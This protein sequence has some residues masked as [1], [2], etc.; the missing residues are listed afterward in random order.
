MKKRY[1]LQNIIIHDY[2]QNFGGGERLVK[3]L[4]TKKF[5]K[6]IV[7]YDNN[8]FKKY[9]FKNIKLQTLFSFNTPEIIKKI[10]LINKFSN[11]SVY[12]KNCIC[13]GNYSLFTEIH[14]KNKIAYIH[15]IPKIF[16]RQKYFYSKFSI[17]A[18]LAKIIFFNFKKKYVEKINKFD[19]LVANSYFT[20][21]QLKKLTKKKIHVI[22]PPIETFKI[23][24]REKFLNYYVFNNRHEIE[25]NLYEVLLAFRVLTK[26]KLIVLSKGSL[27]ENLKRKFSDCKNIEFKGLVSNKKYIDYITNCKAVINVSNDEDFGMGAI[28]PMQFGKITLCLNQGGYKETTTNNFNALHID[29]KNISKDLI[30]KI[31][32]ID[33]KLLKKL[34]KNSLKT[35]QKFSQKSFENKIK[36]LII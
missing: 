4:L 23:K 12:C 35:F 21:R 18:I 14:A 27:T 9:F 16:F 31:N 6:L 8:I 24:Q 7:G 22:Y 5:H 1:K 34:S 3:I 15:S 29:N 33:N 13:S 26:E 17:K 19:H 25:K 10:L 2:F 32:K 30:R 11:L 20:Q 28:E 36:K